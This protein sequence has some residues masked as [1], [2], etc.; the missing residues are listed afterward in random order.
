MLN[1]KMWA[2]PKKGFHHTKLSGTFN[3]SSL[4]RQLTY[5]LN[6]AVLLFV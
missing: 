4:N 1:L 3:L 6:I 2:K 5:T